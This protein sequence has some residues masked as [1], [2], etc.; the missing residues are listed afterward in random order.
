MGQS[1]EV[2]T[3]NLNVSLTTIIRGADENIDLHE[4]PLRSPPSFQVSML[5]DETDQ[6]R[7][8]LSHSLSLSKQIL[9]LVCQIFIENG[10]LL[11]GTTKY[12]TS[13]GTRGYGTNVGTCGRGTSP[14]DKSQSRNSSPSKT[15]TC[16]I[17]LNI[18]V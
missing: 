4:E 9:Q 3:L 14:T 16:T 13:V 6:T 18:N 1:V 8:H 12:G 15:Y 17:L 5:Q 11:T 2:F 7:S 10:C